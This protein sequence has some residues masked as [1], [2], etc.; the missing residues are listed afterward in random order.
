M[1]VLIAIEDSSTREELINFALQQKFPDDS[2]YLIL[3]VVEPIPLAGLRVGFSDEKIDSMNQERHRLGRSLIMKMGTELRLKYPSAK[4]EELVL[5]GSARE[6]IIERATGW[7]AD[8]I[9]MGT[10]GRSGLERVFLGSVSLA[11]LA[12]APCSVAIVRPVKRADAVGTSDR[13]VEEKPV[14]EAIKCK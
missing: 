8:L 14:K 2:E 12:Q 10:H 4:I 6:L 5:D 11:V 7:Q 9:V 1:K 13:A 3:H